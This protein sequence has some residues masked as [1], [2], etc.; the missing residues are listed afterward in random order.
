[1]LGTIDVETTGFRPGY[2]DIIEICCII[3]D[4]NLEPC[5][6]IMPFVMELQPRRIENIDL[7]ALRIQGK[8]LDMVVK[9]KMCKD[10]KRLVKIATVGCDADL[11]AEMF[12]EWFDNLRLAPFKKIMPIACNWAFDRSFI[13]DWLGDE[14]FNQ[15]FHPQYRDLMSMVLFDN[16]VADWRGE[17]YQ[18]PKCNLQYICTTLGIERPGAH[19]ALDDVVATA[20]AYK[21]LVQRTQIRDIP[22]G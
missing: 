1:M 2:H 3:L 10:R 11:A 4:K 8:D 9:D 12:G 15:Y 14:A 7:E 21:K 16:D 18:Y 17:Q 13:I 19:N 20:Q 6:N 22:H 5:D